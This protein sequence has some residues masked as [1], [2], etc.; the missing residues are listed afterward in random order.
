MAGT[1][2]YDREG[3]KMIWDWGFTFSIIPKII[4]AMW[5]TIAATIIGFIIAAIV[6]LIWVL[7]RRS[8][9]KPLA[10]LVSCCIE[11]IRNTP[12]LVQLFFLFYVLPEIGVSLSPFVCGVIGLGVHY[13]TYLSEVYRSGI[14]SVEK[15][16]WEAGIALNFTKLDMWKKIILPQAVAPVIPMFGNYFIVMF[17]E[18]PLLSAITLV[19]MMQAAKLIGSSS[20]RYLEAFTL[21]GILFLLL[22]YPASIAVRYAEEKI[23]RKFGKVVA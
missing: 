16:Q 10:L 15:G 18:T 14:E 17:K 4:N 5:V 2:I 11:F 9:F 8:S 13:S 22:S 1:K 12:L 7:G 23:S 21:V 6:G 20:F 3:V 19:E